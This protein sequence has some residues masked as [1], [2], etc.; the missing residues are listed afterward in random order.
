MPEAS[1]ALILKLGCPS[2][3]T[4]PRHKPTPLSRTPRHTLLHALLP[5]FPDQLLSHRTSRS[6]GICPG[7]PPRRGASTLHS[8]LI[9]YSPR[10][11]MWGA[12]RRGDKD[13][14]RL[15]HPH[16]KL[17]DF[18]RGDNAF[19]GSFKSRK[20]ATSRHRPTP[21]RPPNAISHSLLSFAPRITAG[22]R[23]K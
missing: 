12:V 13:T 22:R 11:A 20:L 1:S 7:P 5:L 2:T 4:P 14:F 15:I 21:S 8:Q 9:N 23:G 10:A 19:H 17:G 3:S 6:L 16:A 18:C